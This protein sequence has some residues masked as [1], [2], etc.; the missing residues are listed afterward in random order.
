[1]WLSNLNW[2]QIK[3]YLFNL[4]THIYNKRVLSFIKLRIS[5]IGAINPTPKISNSPLS[6]MVGY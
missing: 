4:Q 6:Y 3:V 5:R 1:M 2:V